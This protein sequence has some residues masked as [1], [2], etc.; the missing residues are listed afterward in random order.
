MMLAEH[1]GRSDAYKLV[2]KATRRATADRSSLADALAADPAV[3]K[4][5]TRALIR[6]A[7]HT[8]QYLGAARVFRRARPRAMD[9]EPVGVG[10]RHLS[11]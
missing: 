6:A 1:V 5:V 7:P 8:G 10:L 3:C 4:H 2:E 9:E 11:T